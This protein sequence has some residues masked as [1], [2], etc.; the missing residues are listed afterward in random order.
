MFSYVSVNMI[1]IFMKFYDMVA[2]SG[3]I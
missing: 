1:Q 2:R 3:P